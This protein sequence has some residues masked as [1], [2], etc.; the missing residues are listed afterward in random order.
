[1]E[2]EAMTEK[3]II[4]LGGRQ[5]LHDRSWECYKAMTA[6]MMLRWLNDNGIAATLHDTA[7]WEALPEYMEDQCAE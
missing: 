3:T 1:M 6:A 4:V 7:S 2:D 5:H